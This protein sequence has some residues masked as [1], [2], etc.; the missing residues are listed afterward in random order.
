MSRSNAVAA[1]AVVVVVAV[2]SIVVVVVV[3]VVV[4]AHSNAAVGGILV[5][6]YEGIGM[7]LRNVVVADTKGMDSGK[8]QSG[9][10]RQ[11]TKELTWWWWQWWVSECENLMMLQTEV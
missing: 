4:V 5:M 11:T 2:G 6:L 1:V 7:T 9:R 10:H 8:S 3:V